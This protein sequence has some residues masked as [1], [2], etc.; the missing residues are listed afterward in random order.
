MINFKI[1]SVDSGVLSVEKAG[2]PLQFRVGEVVN[3][4]VLENLPTG[5]IELK[6]KGSVV[7]AQTSI[8]MEK[9]SIAY[10]KVTGLPI[11]GQQLTLKY[12][13]A[14]PKEQPLDPKTQ[15]LSGLVKSLSASVL[16]NP[17]K[18]DSSTIQGLLKSLPADVSTIPGSIRA[19]LQELLTSVLKSSGQSISARLGAILGPLVPESEGDATL[20][21]QNRLMVDVERL[22]GNALKTSL[23]NTGVVFEAKLRAEALTSFLEDFQSLGEQ[24][25]S[26]ATKPDADGPAVPAVRH[27][28]K[29]LLIALKAAIDSGE[30][31][32]SVK[33][34]T[35]QQAESL[36]LAEQPTLNQQIEHLLKDVETFQLLSKTTD[37]FYTFLPIHWYQLRDADIAFKRGKTGTHGA[38]FFCRINLDLEHDGFVSAL[39]I[40]NNADYTVSF[41]A[42]KT[43]L[44]NRL[45]TYSGQLKE[46]FEHLGLHLSAVN[47]F[48]SR[49]AI[50]DQF[51]H[52]EA[53]QTI[54]SVQA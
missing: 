25:A 10:F 40:K 41:W 22:N 54:V 7:T 12:L 18:I 8:P 11:D 29:A 13:G 23:S 30:I 51:D 52:I 6:I 53:P 15:A 37:S 38:H 43:A 28:L 3:A 16:S 36:R 2:K 14:E 19:Q 33:A 44:K 1:L 35:S 9:D 48:D 42:E 39:I 47:I 50:H 24:S 49:D 26:S 45:Q 46:A 20:P 31:D 34:P 5:S 21:L 32:G 4:E 17:E 27:D